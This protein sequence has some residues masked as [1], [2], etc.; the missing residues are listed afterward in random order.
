MLR[1]GECVEARTKESDCRPG[2]YMNGIITDFEFNFYLPLSPKS[3]WF[4]RKNYQKENDFVVTVRNGDRIFK[5][6]FTGRIYKKCRKAN[7][8]CIVVRVSSP[9]TKTVKRV[10]RSG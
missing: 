2:S 4:C 6:G 3:L 10:E 7:S 1:D 5:F 9:I 8:I